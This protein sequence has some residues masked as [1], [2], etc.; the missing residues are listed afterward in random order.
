MQGF[1]WVKYDKQDKTNIML[2][3]IFKY[4]DTV[5]LNRTLLNI[6]VF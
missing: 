2:P 3:P 6:S 1:L 5:K 4:F